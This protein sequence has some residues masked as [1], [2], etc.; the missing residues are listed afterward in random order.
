MPAGIRTCFPTSLVHE[1]NEKCQA[2]NR[3]AK[4]TKKTRALTQ[5]RIVIGGG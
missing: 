5:Q 3:Q 4:M 2:K 1:R